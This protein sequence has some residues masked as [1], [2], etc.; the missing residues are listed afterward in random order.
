MADEE[1]SEKEKK[2]KEKAEKK[3]AKQAAK[4]G[5]FSATVSDGGAVYT[6]AEDDDGFSFSVLLIVLFIVVIWIAILCLLVKLDIGGFG[7][8]ILYPVLK[9]V[10][11]VNRILPEQVESEEYIGEFDNLPDALA[12]IDRLNAQIADLK[13]TLGGA[14]EEESEEIKALKEEI[15]RLRTFEDSQIEFDKQK[16]EFYEEVVFAEKAPDIENYKKYYEDIDPDNAE[17]LYKQVVAQIEQNKE[18]D[19]Y[20]KAYS[21]M[22]PKQAAAI[23]EMMTDNLELVATILGEMEPPARAK[24]LGV[25]SADVA[26]KLTKIMDPE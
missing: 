18:M 4:N 25:M 12:E 11:V 17:Y 9:D 5:G 10:P 14:T 22:K 8:E 1:L 23:F 16:T 26:S 13:S 3:A 20:V 2:K 21:E 19:E 6:D 7:S 15:I 24:I